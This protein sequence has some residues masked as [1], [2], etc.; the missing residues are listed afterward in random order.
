MIYGPGGYRSRD[1]LLMGI[2]LDVIMGALA[3]W[4]IP[5]FWPLNAP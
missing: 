4:L 5:V 2:P 3:I 1:Y